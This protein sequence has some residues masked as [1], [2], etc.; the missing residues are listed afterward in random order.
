[1]VT[2]FELDLSKQILSLVT[3]SKDD[4]NSTSGDQHPCVIEQVNL[5]PV[6]EIERVYHPKVLA[7]TYKTK[8]KKIYKK[9]KRSMFCAIQH[10]RNSKFY[11]HL[12]FSLHSNLLDVDLATFQRKCLQV[13]PD[14][15]IIS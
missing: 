14:F 4:A 6:P 3:I 8:N 9:K 1:M 7:G 15:W 10:S 2:R 12:V 5:P 13:C 11:T